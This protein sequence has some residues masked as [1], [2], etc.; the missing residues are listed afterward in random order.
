MEACENKMWNTEKLIES[1]VRDV[2]DCRWYHGQI[3]ILIHECE[4]VHIKSKKWL[5]HF[6]GIQIKT[7][8]QWNH[9][10]GKWKNNQNNLFTIMQIL[11]LLVKYKSGCLLPWNQ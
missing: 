3:E 1:F 11:H 4:R 9:F 10:I 2:K 6:T 5:N 8:I 7:Q